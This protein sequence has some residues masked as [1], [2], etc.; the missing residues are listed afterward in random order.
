[1]NNTPD[2]NDPKRL[3]A[4]GYDHVAHEYA[5]LEQNTEWPR[6]LWLKKVLNR[7]EPGSAVLDLGCGS[8]DPADVEIAKEHKVTGVDISRRQ[9]NLARQ[10]VPSGRFLHADAGS[11]RFPPASFDAVVS[12]YTIEHI[13]R[14]E[15]QTILKCIHEW[16]KPGGFLLISLEAGDYDDVTGE[17][18]GVPMFIS[19]YDPETMRGMVLEAGF[20]M[21]ETAIE[22]QVE[23]RRDI[24]YLWVLGYKP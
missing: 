10:K 6:I 23:G 4:R 2:D 16:L 7:L 13:P 5:R 22:T 3:V 17:W 20:E 9:I 14:E 24:P 8:G 12:F 1:M 11:V 19:C 15:H 18:L 21:V